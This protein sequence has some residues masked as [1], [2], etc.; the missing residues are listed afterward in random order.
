[1]CMRRVWCVALHDQL[2]SQVQA[3]EALLRVVYEIKLTVLLGHFEQLNAKTQERIDASQAA[4][5]TT[6]V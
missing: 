6:S 4:Y 5:V 2:N 1:M 3:V